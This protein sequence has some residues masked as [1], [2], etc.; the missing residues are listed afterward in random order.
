VT[1][2]AREDQSRKKILNNICEFPY[3]F[4][5]R[6]NID[7]NTYLNG[8]PDF[9]IKKKNRT[10]YPMGVSNTQNQYYKKRGYTSGSMGPAVRNSMSQGGGGGVAQ[11][12]KKETMY[13]GE[14]DLGNGPYAVEIITSTTDDLVISA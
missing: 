3:Q 12:I 4:Q 10:Q 13:I 11:I 7:G 14:H 8:P 5:S 9:I 1:R 2:W 6:E